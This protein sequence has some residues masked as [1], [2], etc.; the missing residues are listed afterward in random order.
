MKTLEEARVISPED[1]ELLLRVKRAVQESVPSATVLLYG[2]VA[3][4]TQEAES[5]YDIFVLTDE[6][7]SPPGEEKARAAVFDVEM[8]TG[9][10][11]TL[12]FCSRARWERYPNMP[13]HLEIAQ[14]GILL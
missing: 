13:F 7:L 2:S 8:D 10:V 3:R 4:G 11:L 6:A 12:Q 9:R 1:K 5:D 14:D